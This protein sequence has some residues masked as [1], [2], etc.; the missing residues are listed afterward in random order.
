MPNATWQENVYSLRNL[1][2]NLAKSEFCQTKK[3]IL[4]RYL[5][6][7][8]VNRTESKMQNIVQYSA[9]TNESSL[10]RFL[11]M[12]VYCRRILHISPYRVHV[13]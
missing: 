13:C 2:A 1:T 7:G 4:A 10:R 12:A 5:D 3:H 11:G 6:N 9:L 8:C